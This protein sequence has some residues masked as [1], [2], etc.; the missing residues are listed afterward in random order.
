MISDRPKHLLDQDDYKRLPTKP[1]AVSFETFPELVRRAIGELGGIQPV[2]REM[3]KAASRELRDIPSEGEIALFKAKR[4]LFQPIFV[5]LS[6]AELKEIGGTLVAAPNALSLLPTSKRGAID[7]RSI[8][9]I[10]HLEAEPDHA[11]P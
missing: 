10:A 8:E 5:V 4:T 2:I 3:A 11:R 1:F 7:E 9:E 6:I